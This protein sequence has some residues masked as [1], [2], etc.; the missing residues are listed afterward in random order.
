MAQLSL[1]NMNI[2]FLAGLRLGIVLAYEA[3]APRFSGS[4]HRP[5]AAK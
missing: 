2:T 4:V 3:F 1:D 5:D